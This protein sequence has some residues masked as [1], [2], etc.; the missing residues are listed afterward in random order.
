MTSSGRLALAK[1]ILFFIGM[2]TVFLSVFALRDAEDEV[3]MIFGELPSATV[4]SAAE[5]VSPAVPQVTEKEAEEM[6]R[7]RQEFT[8]RLKLAYAVNAVIGVL[9]IGCALLVNRMPLISTV[10]G[11]TLY[12]ATAALMAAVDPVLLARG[13]FVRVAI[14]IALIL[15]VN[16]AIRTERRRRAK[17]RRIEEEEEMAVNGHE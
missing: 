5:G 2:V 7:V 10:T 11:L 3:Q 15:A 13:I 14:V 9:F 4:S 17:R 1:A 16:A 12:L 8:S 6:R